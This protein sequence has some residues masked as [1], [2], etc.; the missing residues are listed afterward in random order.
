M[1][2]IQ[3]LEGSHALVTLAPVW[4]HQGVLMLEVGQE[5]NEVLK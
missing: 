3:G 1:Q 5:M 2:D 4:F